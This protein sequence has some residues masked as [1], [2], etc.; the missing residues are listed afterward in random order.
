MKV[1]ILGAGSIAGTMAETVNKMR[2]VELYAVGSRTVE[3]AKTFAERFN[4]PKYYGSYEQLAA[5]NNIDLMYI[6]TPHSNHYENS[7]LC[8][9]N[10]RNVL[11]EKAFTANAKQAKEVIGY[12]REHSIFISEAIWTRFMPM[13]STLDEL[14]A[15]GIIGEIS[16]LTANLGY[17][18]SHVERL[19]KPELAGGALLDL[20]VYTINFSLMAFGSNIKDIK[21]SC[22]KNSYGVDKTNSIILTYEDGKTAILHSNAAA[23]TDRLG[24]IYGTKGRI[25]FQNINNCEG[26]KVIPINGEVMTFPVPPQI[27]G[28]EYEVEAS[29]AA[30]KDGRIETDFMPHEETIRVMEIMDGL[31]KEWGVIFPFE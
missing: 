13:R 28:Y 15:S 1:G 21:S 19:Q 31:R 20:G 7:M 8:L 2:G 6:A 12:A 14:L 25:E 30:I 26:I 16:S 18:L 5:D 3:K 17:E 10:G 9:K 4:I 22:V 11:C 24:I 23:Y 29:L 27:T